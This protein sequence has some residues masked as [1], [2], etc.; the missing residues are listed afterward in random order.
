MSGA[1]RNADK[2]N[3]IAIVVA[4]VCGSVLVYVSIVLLQ[5]YYANDSAEVQTMADYGGQDTDF[6][7]LRTEQLGHIGD[8]RGNAAPAPGSGKEQ[9]FTMPIDR[10]IEL[11]VPAAKADPAMLVPTQGRADKATIQP[12]FGRPKALTAPPA[13]PT[14]GPGAGSAAPATP[15]DGAGSGAGSGSGSGAGSATPAT[16]AG[17]GSAAAAPAAPKGNGP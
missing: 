10:A 2:L 16:A 6:R 17:S 11:I 4:G 7:S 12:I 15:A 8:Y 3:T 9:T 13:T 14:D 5:A 1:P